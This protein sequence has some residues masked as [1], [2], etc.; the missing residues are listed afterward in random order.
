MLMALWMEKAYRYYQ[1]VRHIR[2]ISKKTKEMAME[3][4]KL[5]LDATP[6]N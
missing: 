4:Q 6:V 1:L 2:D 3:K 5:K